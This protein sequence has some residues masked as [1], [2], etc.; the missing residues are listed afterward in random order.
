[1]SDVRTDMALSKLSKTLWGLAVMF[2]G[3]ALGLGFRVRVRVGVRVRV[4]VK[5]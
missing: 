4:R 2:A 3:A 1:M 5:R